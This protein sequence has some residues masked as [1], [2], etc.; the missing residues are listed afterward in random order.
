MIAHHNNSAPLPSSNSAGHASR[1]LMPLRLRM[2]MAICPSQNTLH[3]IQ[4]LP[5]TLAPLTPNAAQQRTG[6]SSATD[7]Y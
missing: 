6:E 5:G 2:M 3:E 1:G 7:Q 4:I